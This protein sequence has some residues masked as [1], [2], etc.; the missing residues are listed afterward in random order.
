LRI[1][2]QAPGSI[3]RKVRIVITDAASEMTKRKFIIPRWAPG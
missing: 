1:E 2:D 3:T